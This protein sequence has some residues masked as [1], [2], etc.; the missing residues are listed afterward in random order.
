MRLAKGGKKIWIQASYNPIFDH[1][2]KVV[3]VVKFATDI[4]QRVHVVEVITASLNQ[5]AK[6]DLTV[7]INKDFPVEFERLKVDFNK[8]TQNSHEAM[9][10]IMSNAGLIREDVAE[11]SQSINSLAI[12]TEKQAAELGGTAAEI[13]E[14]TLSVSNTAAQ[15]EEAKII[16]RESMKNSLK[17]ASIMQ[18]TVEAMARIS[19]SSGQIFMITKTMEEISFQTNLLALNAGVEAARA[20]EAG[21]GFAV[22]ASE[23]RALA[24][25]SAESAKDISD[26]IAVSSAEV[27]KGNQL[28]ETA[29]A[30]ISETEISISEI[31]AR[32]EEIASSA[33]EQATTLSSINSTINRLDNVTQENAAMFEECNAATQNLNKA[34]DNLIESTSTFKTAGQIEKAGD[35]DRVSKPHQESHAA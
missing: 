35:S 4:T 19:Q 24:Q 18:E 22:V 16:A 7:Q 21:R 9:G 32:I 14:L 2:G 23:V 27:E 8:A 5:L 31:S 25:R 20:G 3:K 33:S 12:R 15:S 6:G 1:L 13:E 30:T 28:V 10:D 29:S 17:S 34:A 11:I 26:L